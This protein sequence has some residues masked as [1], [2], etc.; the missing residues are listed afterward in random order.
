VEKFSDMAAGKKAAWKKESQK[1]GEPEAVLRLR[2]EHSGLI[3]ELQQELAELRRGICK[4]KGLFKTDKGGTGTTREIE[5]LGVKS[6][7]N[8]QVGMSTVGATP[9]TLLTAKCS[10]GKITLTFSDDPLT[11]HELNWVVD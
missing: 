2:T 8:C 9:V 6:E 7:H 3:Q 1:T 4:F 5:V 11:D 10:Y